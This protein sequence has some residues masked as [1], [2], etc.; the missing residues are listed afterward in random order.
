ML[1]QAALAA[2]DMLSHTGEI[3]SPTLLIVELIVSL[4]PS[5]AV[6][7][8]SLMPSHI[9]LAVSEISLVTDEMVSVTPF[10]TSLAVSV[11][12]CHF[13]PTASD[14]LSN[15]SLAASLIG[16]N[17]SAKKPPNS[18]PAPTATF[19]PKIAASLTPSHT[20][21]ALSLIG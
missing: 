18:A 2:S 21:L 3:A 9:E 19:N 20:S 13:S 11:M 8:A 6:L 15:A 4:T 7:A 17:C 14:T 10:Q 12:D 1:S 16:L 5:N